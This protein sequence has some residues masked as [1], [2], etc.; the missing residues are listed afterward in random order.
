MTIT[1]FIGRESHFRGK[2]LYEIASNLKNFGEGRVVTRLAFHN[3]YP[4]KSFYRL[5]KVVPNFTDT[6]LRKGKAWGEKVFRGDNCGVREINSGSKMDWK[7]IER[8]DE[9]E[10]CKLTE[11]DKRS[12]TIVPKYADYPPLLGEWLQMD[13]R[14]TGLPLPKPFKLK[15]K[16]EKSF[17]NKAVQE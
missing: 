8:E 1:R 7:L 16:I 5:T 13:Y 2:T 15:L 9:E 3:R 10:F 17:T 6:D 11:K 4:E 12:P 14:R